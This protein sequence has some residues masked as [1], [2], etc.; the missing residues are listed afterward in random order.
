MQANA[1]RKDASAAAGVVMFFQWFGGA[2]MTCVAKTV[3]TS[4]IDPLLASAAPEINPLTVIDAGATELQSMVPADEWGGVLSAYNHAI[5]H[6]FVR[7]YLVTFTFPSFGLHETN[8]NVGTSTCGGLLCVCHRIWDGLEEFKE[9][10]AVN[11]RSRRVYSSGILAFMYI[12][13]FE[14]KLF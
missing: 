7:K 9:S 5:S 8:P 4:S 10:S 11:A 12:I 2:I 1:P 6:V 14:Y 3:F 13:S